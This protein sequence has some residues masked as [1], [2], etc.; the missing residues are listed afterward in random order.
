MSNPGTGDGT[1]ATVVKEPPTSA[2]RNRTATVGFGGAV[3][4]AALTAI[5]AYGFK[6]YDNGHPGF[7][8]P[9]EAM[10]PEMGAVIYGAIAG[11]ITA[12]WQGFAAFTMR[13]SMILLERFE[14]EHHG[15][16]RN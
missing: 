6:L 3:S 1:I 15:A 8:T 16:D 2:T 9:M 12:A 7:E 13:G 5:I 14:E 10:G 11:A 4:T